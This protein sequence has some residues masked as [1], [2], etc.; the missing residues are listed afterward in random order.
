MYTTGVGT[1]SGTCAYLRRG[2]EES[3]CAYAWKG[4]SPYEGA[5]EGELVN[6]VVGTTVVPSRIQN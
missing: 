4:I 3:V 6:G 1:L 2:R 5:L